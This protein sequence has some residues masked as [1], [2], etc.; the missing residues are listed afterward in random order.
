M[1]RLVIAASLL[2][3]LGTPMAFAQGGSS[4]GHQKPPYAQPHNTPTRHGPPPHA[5]ANGRAQH[6][7]QAKPH[8]AQPHHSQWSR[9]KRLPAGYR[10]NVVTD[11]RRYHLAPPP[12]GY[13]WV[14]VNNEYLMIG[15]VSGLI[16]SIAQGG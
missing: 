10:Q 4:Q 6:H 5:Q 13:K 3:V 7:V 14:R 15:I 11:Y 1:K 2:S 16:S 9:G 12:R 8:H